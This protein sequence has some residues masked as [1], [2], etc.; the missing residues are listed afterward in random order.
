MRHGKR[1]CD[2]GQRIA[3]R[4][5]GRRV[6]SLQRICQFHERTCRQQPNAVRSGF[7]AWPECSGGRFAVEQSPQPHPPRPLSK[8]ARRLRPPSSGNSFCSILCPL[9]SSIS[10]AGLCTSGLPALLGYRSLRMVPAASRF[11]QW[12]RH[13]PASGR[14]CTRCRPLRDEIG[15]ADFSWPSPPC[16]ILCWKRRNPLDCKARNLWRTFHSNAPPNKSC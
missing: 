4:E 3:A 14:R 11:R 10:P 5:K 2:D 12:L 1:N 6:R 9:A 16:A 8:P 15:D 13:Y 7:S